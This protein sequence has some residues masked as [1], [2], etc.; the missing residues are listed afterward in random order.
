MRERIQEKSEESE[1]QVPQAKGSGISKERGERE[2][3]KC[4]RKAVQG[5]TSLPKVIGLGVLVPNLPFSD[6]Q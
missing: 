6:A 1:A 5:V 3:A 2:R 4:R